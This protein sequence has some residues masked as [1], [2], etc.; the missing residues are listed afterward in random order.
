MNRI[1][2]IFIG[3]F[4][5]LSINI[6]AQISTPT[7]ND[8]SIMTVTNNEP[9]L[10]VI[11]KLN[12]F[13][14]NVNLNRKY[15]KD[16]Y[17][18]KYFVKGIIVN[19]ITNKVILNG[20][21]IDIGHIANNTYF[22]TESYALIDGSNIPDNSQYLLRKNF[23]TNNLTG[24]ID[25][26][27]F[28]K[29][30]YDTSN[31]PRSG[32]E[33]VNKVQYK[34]TDKAITNGVLKLDEFVNTIKY[35]N[36]EISITNNVFD[37]D[38]YSNILN[39]NIT[40]T[41]TN[42]MT[43]PQI[44]SIIDQ[45][46]R[47][48]NN[49]QL[50]FVFSLNNTS[51]SDSLRFN[52]FFGGTV[53]ICGDMSE[54]IP[55]DIYGITE[56]KHTTQATTLYFSNN[57]LSNSSCMVFNNGSAKIKI[58]N[59]KFWYSYNNNISA[60]E[61]NINNIYVSGCYFVNSPSISYV[62]RKSSAIICS[63]GNIRIVRSVFYGWNYAMLAKNSGIINSFDCEQTYPEPNHA[64]V[65][66]DGGIITYD[67]NTT[68]VSSY[69][70]NKNIISNGMINYITDHEY[71][72]PVLTVNGY[73]VSQNGKIEQWG[74]SRI[75]N[76]VPATG[77]ATIVPFPIVFSNACLN[78]QLTPIGNI[79]AASIEL[80]VQAV[81]KSNFYAKCGSASNFYWRA[82]GY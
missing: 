59:I 39:S 80:N 17:T 4:C 12:S 28:A 9:N 71:I 7:I 11:N 76:N 75:T 19:G 21:Y 3:L 50:T 70:D 30:L 66:I 10:N 56:A 73:E 2:S 6:C 45:Q 69:L 26:S 18:N 25:R 64:Y 34:N 15:I 1:K 35:R 43:T 67:T 46:P 37:L 77:P 13:F 72:I 14:N 42:G 63:G 41:I 65:A 38:S 44:Q 47:N 60:I 5:V 27:V 24:Y 79:P 53:I 16:I 54:S 49:K 20:S 68:F 31:I 22:T 51:I 33:F 82:I 78:I 8:I 32:S 55:E 52:G 58:L 57:T 29:Y 74:T 62:D 61:C 40:V 81:T 48:L 23:S 36:Q